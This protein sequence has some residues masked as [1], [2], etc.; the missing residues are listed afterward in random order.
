MAMDTQ[1][2][3]QALANADCVADAAQVSAALDAM[4]QAITRQLADADP[5]ALV[6]MNGG[7]FV[8]RQLLPRLAFPL[9]TGYLHVTRY[10]D[11]LT[12]GGLEWRVPPPAAAGRTV[13]VIDDILDEGHTLEAIRRRLVESGARQVFTA[14]LVDKQHCRKA[15][16]GLRANFTGLELPDRF[17]FGCGMDIKGYWR[18][19]PAIHALREA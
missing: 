1:A 2:A 11:A 15:R 9:E 6:V 12:G 19:L 5:L 14:V 7:L 18:N 8:A 3:R 17:L 16:P 13:L 10:G 4:A